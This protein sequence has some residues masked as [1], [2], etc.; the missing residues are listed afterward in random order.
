MSRYLSLEPDP[1]PSHGGSADRRARGLYIAARTDRGLERQNN[2]DHAAFADLAGGHAFEPP[3]SVVVRLPPGEV[4]A[5]IV[6]LVCDGMGGEAG[7]EVAS[8]LAIDTIVPVLRESV[9]RRLRPRGDPVAAST[10]AEETEPEALAHE[11]LL[12]R[13]LVASIEAASARIKEEA[14]RQPRLAR[15]GTT[16]T[17][18]A[19]LDGAG[20]RR[21]TL[22]CAQV[23]DSRAYLLRG[24]SLTQ[25]THDQTMVEYL[26]RSG[27]PIENAH[28]M[29]GGHVILQAVGSSTRLDVAITQTPLEDGDTVL[30]CSDGLSG[31]VAD[32]VI[33]ETLLAY[34][35]PADVCDG[36][37]RRAL[38]AG[39]PD[40]VTCI[41]ARLTAT[42]ET[43][44]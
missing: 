39:G 27:V 44:T 32:D 40:N 20:G 42:A 34:E 22:V 5:P 43:M 35:D 30:V 11:R 18:A 13:G 4:R 1:F 21:G 6:A 31:V 14:R 9:S 23:G 38:E 29:V 36:L 25:V 3:A 15:M 10:R 26:R 17:V 2:E 12:A 28:E 33:R 16:A 37:V 41:V 19:F 7:G 24:G 8:R